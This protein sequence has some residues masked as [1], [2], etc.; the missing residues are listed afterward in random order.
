MVAWRLVSSAIAYCNRGY[1]SI[2]ARVR[3]VRGKRVVL[4]KRVVEDGSGA[5][6]AAAVSE[7]GRDVR[8][9]RGAM[10]QSGKGRKRVS[11]CLNCWVGRRGG[12]RTSSHWRSSRNKFFLSNLT[13][14]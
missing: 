13:V 5:G 4:S 8:E 12:D 6:S 14:S 2:I 11:G 3:V 10:F 7:S 9:G 1:G